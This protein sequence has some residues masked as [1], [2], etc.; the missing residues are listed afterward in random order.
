MIWYSDLRQ[1]TAL[2]DVL[3]GNEFLGALS[4]YFQC[5]AGAVLDHG[6]EVL[7][8]I[9]DAVLAIFHVDG[10]DGHARAATVARAASRDAERRLVTVNEERRKRGDPTL[11]FGLALHSG[12]L[13]FGN[14]GVP[15]R[16]EFS[17]VGP[18]ANEAARIENLT[19]HLG[20]RVLVSSAFADLVLLDTGNRWVS[21]A[22]TALNGLLRCSFPHPRVGR[23]LL[24]DGYQRCAC[25]SHARIDT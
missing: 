2:A 6:G 19:K 5:T 17:V 9:G 10:V 7:R 22:L 20:R 24:H 15:E 8:F 11:E 16:L 14:I 21:R 25:A 23:V 12:E 3:P 18:A 13:M 4:D 1:S